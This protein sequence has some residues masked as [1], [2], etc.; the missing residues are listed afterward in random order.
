MLGCWKLLLPAHPYQTETWNVKCHS[1]CWSILFDWMLGTGCTQVA[2][3]IKSAKNNF[4]LVNF[5]MDHGR[6]FAHRLR[7]QRRGSAFNFRS[8]KLCAWM[9]IAISSDFLQPSIL[10]SCKWS[11]CFGHC[12]SRRLCHLIHSF[13]CQLIYPFIH[14]INHPFMHFTIHQIIFKTGWQAGPAACPA[15]SM[16]KFGLALA[17][18][19]VL[20]KKMF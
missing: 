6:L 13:I 1:A 14:S 12:F 7:A 9:C 8:C 19:C 2:W 4:G 15:L 5:W 17:A 10:A 11:W 20:Q 18:G 16:S 3:R